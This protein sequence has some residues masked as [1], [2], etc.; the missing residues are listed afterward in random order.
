MAAAALSPRVVQILSVVLDLDYEQPAN[1]PVFQGLFTVDEWNA[2]FN[3]YSQDHH[4]EPDPDYR[5]AFPGLV[6]ES[7]FEQRQHPLASVMALLVQLGLASKETLLALVS[8]DAT[9][10]TGPSSD[11]VATVTD[12]LEQL[13]LAPPPGGL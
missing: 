3:R 2:L 13:D 6:T 10:A 7:V 5:D 8:D 11:E 12:R 4:R 9:N 1:K